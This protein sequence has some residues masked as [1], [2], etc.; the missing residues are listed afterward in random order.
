[1]FPHSQPKN[2]LSS[3]CPK[4]ERVLLKKT[5]ID[6]DTYANKALIKYLLNTQLISQE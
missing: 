3:L 2:I 5:I 1:M 4:G 6:W